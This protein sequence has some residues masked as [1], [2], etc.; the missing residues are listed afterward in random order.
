MS[1]NKKIKYGPG[2][3][4]ANGVIYQENSKKPL[5]Q[6]N[7]FLKIN[8]I[9]MSEIPLDVQDLYDNSFMSKEKIL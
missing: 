9:L 1:F 2:N 8:G 3:I 7:S 4:D 5:R 6:I